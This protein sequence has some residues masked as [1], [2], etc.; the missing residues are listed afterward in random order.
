[1]DRIYRRQRH[2]YDVT[3]KYYLLGRD[4]LIE[5]LSPPPAAGCSRSAAARRAIWSRR[6]APIRRPQFYGID[7]SAEMLET[8]RAKV[9]REACRRASGSPAPTPPRSIPPAVRRAGLLARLPVL[10]PVDDPR[11]GSAAL[12]RRWPGCSRA[13]SCTSSI[14][15]ARSELPR[16]FRAGLRLW[17]AQFHVIRAMGWRRSSPRSTAAPAR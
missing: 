15:A 17:L 4:R 14:S 7:I 2:L 11:A 8:A 1:M 16:W 3:R 12:A 10:Q 6:R 5:R 9:A 13:A